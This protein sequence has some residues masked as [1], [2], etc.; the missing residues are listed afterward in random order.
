MITKAKYQIIPYQ[1]EDRDIYE[2]LE[3]DPD[4]LMHLWP[5]NMFQ[6]PA[7]GEAIYL[8]RDYLVGATGRDDVFVSGAAFICYDRSNLNV[9]V[10]PDCCVA[11]GVD[12]RAIRDRRLYL[13]WEVGKVPD[14]VLEMASPT[15]ADNDIGDKLGI[16]QRIGVGEYWLF[17]GTGVDLYGEPLVGYRLVD[18]QYRRI[19]LTQEPGGSVRG[20][21]PVL[22]L[23]LSWERRAEGEGWLRLYEPATGQR[24]EPYREVK[25]RA[26]AA[27]AEAE[28]LREELSRLRG[29]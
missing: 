15:T 21:S 17:D 9:R 25:E 28:R 6:D 5:D 10:G 2:G 4:N 1:R 27:E 23:Y 18:G 8:I 24:L 11:V 22:E 13:P 16:Y 7:L 20:Y 3:F 12:A 19:E 29:E 26:E 14:F